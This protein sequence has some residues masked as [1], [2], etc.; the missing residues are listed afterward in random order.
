VRTQ[1]KRTFWRDERGAVAPTFA[2]SLFAL[3]A[4][5]G[6]AF[7]YARLATMDSELQNAADQ[8]AL[9][10]ATQL[11][12]ASDSCARAIGAARDLLKG[13]GDTGQQTGNLSVFANDGGGPKV[14]IPAQTTAC[15]ATATDAVRFYTTAEGTTLATTAAEAKFVEVTV[16]ARIAKFALTPVV[17]AI[18]SGAI[19]ATARAGLGSAICKVPPLMICNPNPSLA[20]NADGKKGWGLMVTGHGNDRS[21]S[22]N[23]VSAWAAGDFGFLEAGTGNNADLIKAL[24]FQNPTIECLQVETGQ[25]NT[26]NPQG[27]YDAVNTR[28]DIYDFSSGNGTALSSCFSGSCPAAPNVTKDLVKEDNTSTSGNSCKIA[29]SGWVLPESQFSPAAKSGAYSALAQ[30]DSDNKIDAMGLPRDNCHY[31]TYSTACANDSSNRFGNGE[32][33]RGDYFNKYHSGRIPANAASMT[34]YETYLW[35]ITNNFIPNNVAAGKSSTPPK[36]NVFQ[37]GRPTSCSSGTVDAGRDRRVLSVAVVNNCSALSGSSKAAVI[38]EWV[39][40]F[41]VEPTLDTRGNGATK[42]QIYMEIIGKTKSGG[43]GSTS[44]QTV[45]RDSPY[46]VQ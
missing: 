27:L 10:A 45:R 13:A 19:D 5:G 6:I 37:Y 15:D 16:A 44:A 46:L 24:A 35:E 31:G 4:A 17:G 41:F 8:A 32:W 25:V 2:L 38:G 26:G 34:R 22:G 30:I 36:K 3:V 42:D 39:D 33:A 29:N 18:K 20:F 1:R 43:N 11:D 9:A 14:T 23:A 7:D 21:G 28:F 12:G 40:M